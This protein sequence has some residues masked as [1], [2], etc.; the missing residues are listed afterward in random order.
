M[1]E[2]KY[3][4]EP[5]DT[6]LCFLRLLRKWWVVCA[7][8]AA[9]AL[10]FGGIYFLSHVVYGPAREYTVEAQFYIEY[11]NAVTQEQQYTFYNKETW[12][13]LIHT[14]LFMDE[15]MRAAA[16]PMR[17]LGLFD[18]EEAVRESVS[19]S[20]FAT[21]LTDVRLVHVT[22]TTN[23]PDYTMILTEALEPAFIKFGETQREI[24]EIRPVLIPKKASL[25]A[26]DHRTVRACILGAALFV[27]FTLFFMYLYAVLDTSFY[28]PLEFERRFGIPMELP[29][30][31]READAVR[32]SVEARERED[33]TYTLYVKSGD[34]NR[35]LAEKTLRDLMKEGKTV[36]GA[37]LVQPD[38]KLIRQYFR[39]GGWLRRKALKKD[40]TEDGRES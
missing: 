27:C 21:L 32:E 9:G 20:V 30:K 6:R 39:T 23:N 17:S 5:L 14:D 4:K 1:W 33:G 13:S 12:E 11:K 3:G 19:R 26:A 10:L 36:A 35:M 31:E 22:V 16:E 2:C 40:G 18:S 25:T 7:S 8:A 29:G 37:V 24:D 28:I 34:H 15:I 38:E